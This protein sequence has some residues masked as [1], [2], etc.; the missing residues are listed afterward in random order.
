MLHFKIA[1][2]ATVCP[3]S[4]GQ[5]ERKDKEK[6]KRNVRIVS[7]VLLLALVLGLGATAASADS[8]NIQSED[9]WNIMLVIDGSGSLDH[10][11]NGET[12]PLGLRY[13]AV[14]N[15]LGTLNDDQTNVGAIV[16]T[17]NYYNNQSDEAM[18]QAIKVNTGLL[19]LN[20][21]GTKDSIMDIIALV[22]SALVG[23]GYN[24]VV[25][26]FREADINVVSLILPLS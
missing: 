14:A 2:I 21:P 1:I 13:Y 26:F 24:L 15:F 8:S 18:R 6:M 11:T 7:L 25:F 3:V 4:T 17:A 12:D 9:K 16:F 23:I 22:H 10:D 5:G 20:V 19:P